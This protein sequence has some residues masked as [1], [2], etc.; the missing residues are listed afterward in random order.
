M[1]RKMT[2][3][4]LRRELKEFIRELRKLMWVAGQDQ[5]ILSNGVE[6]YRVLAWIADDL[7]QEPESGEKQKNK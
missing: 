2:D 3:A 7:D 6:V 5:F 4:Q 1:N